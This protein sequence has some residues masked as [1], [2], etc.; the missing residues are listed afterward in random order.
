MPRL[1]FGACVAPLAVLACQK[2]GGENGWRLAL[3][4]AVV[5]LTFGL[6]FGLFMKMDEEKPAESTQKSSHRLRIFPRASVLADHR[7]LFFLRSG[8][9]IH[10]GLAD[11]VLHRL[12]RACS[13]RGADRYFAALD[14][15]ACR[16]FLVQRDRGKVPPMADDHRHVLRHR[17]LPRP[18]SS[19]APAFRY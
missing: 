17:S 16:P 1:P 9:S 5:L 10:D 7:A 14:L 18:G 13:G 2:L 19:S 12:R 11:Y 8:R 4:I 15:A 6:V 3:E